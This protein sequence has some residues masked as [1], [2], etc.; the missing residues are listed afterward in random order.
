MET[1]VRLAPLEKDEKSEISFPYREA[2]GMLMY[3]AT[4]TRPDLA[5]NPPNPR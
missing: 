5:F 3:L 1:N 4:S 2:I